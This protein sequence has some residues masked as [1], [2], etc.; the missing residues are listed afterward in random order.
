MSTAEKT[1]REPREPKAPILVQG[2]S[3]VLES[4]RAERIALALVRKAH[5]RATALARGGRP[6]G[7]LA[8][9]WA[10]HKA[11]WLAA[12]I[13]PTFTPEHVPDPRGP[14]AGVLRDSSDRRFL[15][16][17]RAHNPGPAPERSDP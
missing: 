11:A 17:L 4:S 5:A 14:R 7:P 12:H 15:A 10:A 9:S 2:P 8:P 16:L 1:P 6:R 3:V 13:D